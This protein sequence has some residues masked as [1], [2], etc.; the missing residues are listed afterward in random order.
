MAKKIA[1]K[2]NNQIS[3]PDLVSNVLDCT[4]KILN[5]IQKE[6]TS[7]RVQ[8]KES[9]TLMIQAKRDIIVE[10]N[11]QRNK[12]INKE[13]KEIERNYSNRILEIQND[14]FKIANDYSEEIKDN[15]KAFN[16]YRK[17]LYA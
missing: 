10:L 16:E 6:N 5:H 7:V 11:N 13:D 2:G 4:D 15:T 1:N 8:T 12:E 3:F 14:I 9:Y 17:D